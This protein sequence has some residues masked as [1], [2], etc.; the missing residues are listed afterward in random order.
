MERVYGLM[1]TD[2]SRGKNLL[3]LQIQK[4]VCLLSI[5]VPYEDTSCS[6]SLKLGSVSF[7]CKGIT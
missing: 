4:L 6:L 3:S 2:I 5:G 7:E 1:K